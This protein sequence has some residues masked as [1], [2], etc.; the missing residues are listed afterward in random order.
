MCVLYKWPSGGWNQPPRSVE[1]YD[2]T[3]ETRHEIVCTGLFDLLTR[4]LSITHPLGAYERHWHF[5]WGHAVEFSHISYSLVRMGTTGKN[6]KRWPTVEW[7]FIGYCHLISGTMVLEVDGWLIGDCL[8]SW[9]TWWPVVYLGICIFG[10]AALNLIDD[11]RYSRQVFNSLQ[12]P[13]RSLFVSLW[14][15]MLYS[16][17]LYIPD[18]QNHNLQ[19][20][21]GERHFILF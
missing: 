19:P 13:Y 14:V 7:A 4:L 5:P 20:V 21:G 1:Y 12:P 16:S 10:S 17:T 18:H 6:S 11:D 3:T 9:F 2:I 15:V 8:T